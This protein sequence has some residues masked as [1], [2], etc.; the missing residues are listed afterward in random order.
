MS[1][2]ES[3][4]PVRFICPK[5]CGECT[6]GEPCC[7]Q[8]DLE[9][10][11]LPDSIVS[12]LARWAEQTGGI[13]QTEPTDNKLTAARIEAFHPHP[14]SLDRGAPLQLGRQI[15]S[16]T[17]QRNSVELPAPAISPRHCLVVR[18]R[19]T[20]DYWVVEQGSET[21][22]YVN[23]RR[24][25]SECLSSDDLVQIGPFAWVF[26]NEDGYLVPVHRI[27]GVAL[28]LRG[29]GSAQRLCDLSVR[30]EPGQLVAIIGPSGAGKST[31]V[32]A[33]VGA[34][35]GY[36]RGRVLA[37]GH[38][39]VQESEWFRGFLGYVSQQDVLHADLH[40][41][42]A[43]QF[44]A[45]L[46]GKQGG[47]EVER[48]LRQVDLSEIKR[49]RGIARNT[50]ATLPFARILRLPWLRGPKGTWDTPCGRLSGGEAKRLRTA[51]ELIAAPRLLI[52][53]EPGSGLDNDREIALLRLL[54]NLSQRGCTV[55][56]V[57]HNQHELQYFDRV[58]VLAG[59][60]L[61]FDGSPALLRERMP[62]GEFQDLDRGLPAETALPPLHAAAKKTKQAPIRHENLHFRER[63]RVLAAQFASLFHRELALI[64]NTPGRRFALPIVVVPAFFALALNFSVPTTDLALLGFLSVLSCIWMGASLSLMS[65]VNE[66]EIL[67]HERLLF[68]R[69]FPYV[70]A[71]VTVLWLLSALQTVSFVALLSWLRS[72]RQVDAMLKDL[73]W[74]A[75][76]LTLLSFAAVGMGLLISACAG[77]NRPAANFLLPL[78]MMLQIAFSVQIAGDGAAKLEEA[79]GEF[80]THNCQRKDCR[81]RAESWMPA[82]GG[83]LCDRCR[84]AEPNSSPS[85][86]PELDA[87]HNS[88]RPDIW[89]S[90][91][92]YLA[93]SRYGDI[94]LRSFAYFIP[95]L[96]L[97]PQ[98]GYR[99]WRWE[100][101]GV[102]VGLTVALPAGA[103]VCLRLG[104][105][106]Q[107]I[108]NLVRTI[109][110][111]RS[112]TKNP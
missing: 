51:A 39:I 41:R 37:D 25:V 40:A 61:A 9:L 30:F 14:I 46:R 8:C 96:K 50:P 7:R 54:R 111:G 89:A 71:K 78:I 108:V 36:D 60:R 42:Q 103:A 22:T 26:S 85:A 55:I 56:V 4:A 79:Y 81:R 69:V 72:Q 31:L 20:V 92:S 33:M 19:R 1:T 63:F 109:A 24:V 49:D 23:G 82:K 48:V 101:L 90:R 76:Y 38:D 93:L 105:T 99:R 17:N 45:E 13:T 91:A 104:D 80:H 106:P 102:L 73:P 10:D 77:R 57:T 68:L 15:A 97:D 52:L 86:D 98:F 112:G 47:S 110:V 43:I 84:A 29:V 11:W 58:L 6:L 3:A 67:E 66:R 59:G 100:A 88:Q 2:S 75:V 34:P 32:R 70:L 28:E 95:D 65:I 94:A 62:T 27:H 44:A 21:G 18:R 12:A 16:D 87:D 5:C 83:W 53:D 64:Q 107:S 74:V 35:G